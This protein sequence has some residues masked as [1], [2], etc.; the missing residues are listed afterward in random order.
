MQR[1]ASLLAKAS[2]GSSAS[3][4]MPRQFPAM[5]MMLS[6]SHAGLML[7]HICP[8]SRALTDSHW[9]SPGTGLR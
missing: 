9:Q 7:A 4:Y 2:E 1:F 8:Y 3:R 6:N 5:H